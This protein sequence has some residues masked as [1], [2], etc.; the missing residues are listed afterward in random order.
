[1]LGEKDKKRQKKT[2]RKRGE[3]LFFLGTKKLNLS[4]SAVSYQEIKMNTQS[5]AHVKA[6]LEAPVIANL[7]AQLQTLQQGTQNYMDVY[8]MFYRIEYEKTYK[9]LYKKYSQ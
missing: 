2:K 7:K 9:E 4:S 3:T 5:T 6:C 1:M 8:M